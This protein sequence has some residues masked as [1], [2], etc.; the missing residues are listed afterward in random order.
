MAEPKLYLLVVQY[1][2]HVLENYVFAES[3]EA[4]ITAGGGPVAEATEQ[5]GL[6][7]VYPTTAEP[8]GTEA[9]TPGEALD[10]IE[11]RLGSRLREEGTHRTLMPPPKTRR[12]I[13]AS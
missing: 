13:S 11:T 3:V 7:H 12:R 5:R 6:L 4:A 10:A 2:R 8:G 9:M 1:K